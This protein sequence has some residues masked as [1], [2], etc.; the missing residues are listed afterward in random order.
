MQPKILIVEDDP[1]IMMLV[2]GVLQKD[3]YIIGEAVNGKE[4]VA[5]AETFIPDLILMDVMMPV[6][7]GF[8][9]CAL[10]RQHP[11]IGATPIIMLTALT[12]LEQKI[13]GFEVGADDYIA[14]PFDAEELALRV[15][16]MLRRSKMVS[17]TPEQDKQGK[18]LSVFSL[19]GGA[20]VTTIASNLAVGLA[21]LWRE[22]VVLVDMNWASGHSAL[23]LNLSLKTTWSNILSVPIEEIDAE[24]VSKVL[25][26]HE[27]GVKVLAAPLSPEMGELVTSENIRYVL[28]LL[29]NQFH[30]VVC[31][32][33]HNFDVASLAALDFSDEIFLVLLPEIAGVH[34]TRTALNTFSRLEFSLVS[35]RLLCNWVFPNHGIANEMIE[36][37]LSRKI[38]LTVP[39]AGDFMLP[40]LNYGVPVVYGDPET[41]VGALFEDLAFAVSKEEHNK[42]KMDKPTEAWSRVVKRAQIRKKKLGK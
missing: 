16:A 14:K 24:F 8:E 40:A 26:E 6:M 21:S 20:G 30:Y 10:I 35:I 19:R 41:S 15:S 28:E 39:Y 32:L 1:V 4:G 37:A 38:D 11:E 12:D 34:S 5:V 17:K 9:A 27:S 22:E 13:K 36:N 3:N 7:D 18:V 33:P 2:K 25:I 31:D 23:S 42:R 29:R